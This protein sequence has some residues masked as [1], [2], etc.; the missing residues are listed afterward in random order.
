MPAAFTALV[1]AGGAASRLGGAKESLQVG[2]RGLLQ[3]SLDVARQAAA[4]VLLLPGARGVPEA[5]V[6]GVR[7]VPDAPGAPGPLGALVA[8]LRAARHDWCLL[9]PC[10]MPF[11]HAAGA[12]ALWQRAQRSGAA[13]V[14]IRTDDGLQPFFAFYHRR[15]LDAVPGPG[16]RGDLSLHGLLAAVPCDEVPV[17]ELPEAGPML[18]LNVNTP[19]DLARAQAACGAGA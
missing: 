5:L 2:G 8:G 6:A 16:T 9:L 3:R 1:L 7:L 4:E 18:F 13:A 19:A 11:L 15:V 14:V 17:R 10:D 12:L